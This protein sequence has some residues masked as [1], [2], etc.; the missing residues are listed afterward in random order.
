[1]GI[2]YKGK[3]KFRFGAGILYMQE[4][5]FAGINTFGGVCDE[6]LR[7]GPTWSVLSIKYV[8]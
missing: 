6:Y 3:T 5:G 1:M 7:C 2:G 4:T 8:K